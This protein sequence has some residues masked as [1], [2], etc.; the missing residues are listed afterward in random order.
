MIIYIDENRPPV[1]AE[2]LNILQK[3][4]N[5]KLREVIDVRSLTD[6]FGRGAKGEWKRE[7][8]STCRRSTKNAI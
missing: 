2:G 8:Y 4:L 7:N 5:A 3:P 1:L 6:E